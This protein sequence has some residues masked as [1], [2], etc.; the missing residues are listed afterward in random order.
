MANEGRKTRRRIKPPHENREHVLRTL[1]TLYNIQYQS[2]SEL[3][4]YD[5]QVCN[6]EDV[7]MRAPVRRPWPLELIGKMI[8]NETT[9]SGPSIQDHPWIVSKYV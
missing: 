4:I 7:K 1:H 3:M 6:T 5:Y 8:T 2:P 9:Y